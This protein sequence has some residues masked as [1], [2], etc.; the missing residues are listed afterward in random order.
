M[1]KKQVEYYLPCWWRQYSIEVIFT[2]DVAAFYPPVQILVHCTVYSHV[3]P[4]FEGFIKD[5]P[6]RSG[7]WFDALHLEGRRF[8]SHSS[9]HVGTLGKSFTRN[10]L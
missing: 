1:Q 6:Y 5:V 9:R 8:E 10:C 2:C 4:T 7:A 3:L